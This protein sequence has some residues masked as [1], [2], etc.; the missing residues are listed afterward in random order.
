MLFDQ[1]VVDHTDKLLG[2]SAYPISAV[3]DEG[4][5][6]NNTTWIQHENSGVHHIN[7]VIILIGSV[8]APSPFTDMDKCETTSA[9]PLTPINSNDI[10]FQKLPDYTTVKTSSPNSP[11]LFFDR[12]LISDT[13]N[14]CV[15][16][17]TND[18]V[19]CQTQPTNISWRPNDSIS[20]HQECNVKR[21]LI[22][23][24]ASANSTIDYPPSDVRMP[25]RGD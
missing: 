22:E 14:I 19:S 18:A 6:E 9:T 3:T 1:S 23:T 8:E 10:A 16:Y 15:P 24:S 20:I 5:P 11:C 4:E 7:E 13:K 2:S 25:Y 17:T 12:S 21:G